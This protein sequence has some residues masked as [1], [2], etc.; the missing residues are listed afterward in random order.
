MHYYILA[1]IYLVYQL[2][3]RGSLNFYFN[4]QNKP[5]INFILEERI[6]EFSGMGYRWFDMRRLS[7]DPLFSNNNYSHFIYSDTGTATQ[8]A[9]KSERF[10]LRFPDKIILQN[11]GMQNNP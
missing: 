5:L 9:L 3:V 1:F 11:P 8:I 7:V 10:A 4:K 6:R 2:P